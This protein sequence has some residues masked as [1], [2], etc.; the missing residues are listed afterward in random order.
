MIR[1]FHFCA[2]EGINEQKRSCC[3]KIILTIT[4]IND[5]S[6]KFQQ[7]Q[8]LPLII[9]VSEFSSINTE[10][11]QMKAFDPDEGINGQIRYTFSKWT[12]ND[13]TI[14]EIFYL[15]PSNGSITLLKQLDYEI[16]TN[17]ELQIQAKDL[18]LNA[19]PSYSTV[20][21]QVQIFR[22]PFTQVKKCGPVPAGT[23]RKKSRQFPAGILLP[24]SSDFRCFPAGS[25]DRNLR[26]GQGLP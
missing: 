23:H 5:N 7:N 14:S 18:G 8:Q 13:Q 20:I 3:T 17:Y 6:P 9:N 25:G 4:D 15:N 1:I 2:Y 26:P 19:I 22:L 21:I 10:L 12:L 11:I 16:R 24:C